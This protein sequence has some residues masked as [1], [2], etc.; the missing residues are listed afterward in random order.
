MNRTETLKKLHTLLRHSDEKVVEQGVAL[1]LSLDDPTVL[2][3]LLDGASV[4]CAGRSFKDSGIPEIVLPRWWKP[5]GWRAAQRARH[6]FFRLLCSSEDP[7]VVRLRDKVVGLAWNTGDDPQLFTRLTALQSLNVSSYGP[8]VDLSSLSALNS[9]TRL[10][11]SGSNFLPEEFSSASLQTLL[12]S[13][14][15]LPLR[16]SPGALP[17]LKVAT[18]EGVEFTSLAQLSGCPA[19]TALA[20]RRCGKLLSLTG[21][22]AFPQLESLDVT[23]SPVASLEPLRGLA[24]LASL[25]LSWSR[26]QDLAVLASLPSL[27]RV[28]LDYTPITSLEALAEL[29]DLEWV[30]FN[31]CPN[32]ETLKGLPSSLRHNPLMQSAMVHWSD[33]SA[34]RSLEYSDGMF[35]RAAVMNL[36]KLCAL[37]S[38]E[39]LIAP[40]LERF[41]LSLCDALTSLAGVETCASLTS[42]RVQGCASL[43]DLSPLARCPSLEVI[44]VRGM[45]QITDV[46]MLE[47]L[48]KLRTVAV[49]GTAVDK[50]TLP[51]ALRKACLFGENPPKERMAPL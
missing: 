5:R 51:K 48:P 30:S 8:Q 22:R 24:R 44:D 49:H 45:S 41:T 46:S 33:L 35:A 50:E 28:T 19:L 6:V 11:L 3:D 7:W 36:T 34:L 15:S 40:S 12:V 10:S 29:P 13:V 31:Q 4:R 26:V 23:F 21:V 1:A 43:R 39:G 2:R 38:L 37:A 32:L 9:L 27:K 20:L 47:A 18:F 14:H 17:A 25:D 16:F 42:V